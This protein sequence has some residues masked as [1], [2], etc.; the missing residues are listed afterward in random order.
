MKLYYFKDPHGNFGDD[1]NPWLWRQLLGD[2]LDDADDE[3]FVGIGTLIN[4]RLPID[5]VKHVF[6]SGMG[7][8]ERPVVDDR[9]VFHAVRGPLTARALGLDE[10][11]AITDSAVL[12]RT[13]DLP[14]GRCLRAKCGFIPT[15]GSIARYDWEQVCRDSDIR[16]ISCQWDVSRVLS[17]IQS[18]D[19]L[20]CEAMHG[21][22]VADALRVPWVAARCSDDILDFK[23]QDWLATLGLPY[24]PIF[25]PLLTDGHRRTRGLMRL[26]VAVKQG[27]ADLGL[28]SKS[29]TAPPPRDSSEQEHA[30]AVRL[31]RAA[32]LMPGVVSADRIVERH[33]DRYEELLGKI[34]TSMG[35]L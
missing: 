12:I 2:V 10:R 24:E 34:R 15:G 29:W 9:W 33:T 21:A 13:V 5:P 16:Y 22:I 23:W 6:G 28:W 25:F 3:L 14:P 26:K 31:L 20:I 18:C 27:L 30:E 35:R 1:L 19:L 11:I 8:G 17:E 4:H 7:Y 32:A